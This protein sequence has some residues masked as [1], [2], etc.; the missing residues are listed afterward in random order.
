MILYGCYFE[1]DVVVGVGGYLASP[2][3]GLGVDVIFCSRV[4][5]LFN[6]AEFLN[7]LM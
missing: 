5:Y 3:H 7:R 1:V 2:S 6:E 4:E